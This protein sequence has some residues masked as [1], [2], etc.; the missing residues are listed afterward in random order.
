MEGH[1]CGNRNGLL[2]AL[3]ELATP[4]P[5]QPSLR[6]ERSGASRNGPL[7]SLGALG[8]LPECFLLLQASLGQ[9]AAFRGGKRFHLAEAS[10]E[11]RVGTAQGAR[12]I[13]AGVARQVGG[14]E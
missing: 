1:S 8:L 11:L 7:A 4:A 13:D 2:L 5:L 9:R 10:L 12:E 6:G 3:L 14:D